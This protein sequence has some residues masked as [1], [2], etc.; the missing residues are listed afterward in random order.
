M[1][2]CRQFA[3]QNLLSG[4]S[5]KCNSLSST[6][7]TPSPP[8]PLHDDHLPTQ[9]AQLL[10]SSLPINDNLLQ[11]ANVVYQR[12][13][14]D[15]QQQLQPIPLKADRISITD[16]INHGLST[17]IFPPPPPPL[18][19]LN[20][21][22][23]PTLGINSPLGNSLMSLP[24][25]KQIE[26]QQL[27]MTISKLQQQLTAGLQSVGILNE[28][29]PNHPVSPWAKESNASWHGNDYGTLSSIKTNSSVPSKPRVTF[30]DQVESNLIESN[31]SSPTVD[32]DSNALFAPTKMSEDNLCD[33][34]EALLQE[35]KQSN[36]NETSN[37]QSDQEDNISIYDNVISS[38]ESHVKLLDSPSVVG[39]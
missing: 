33:L 38:N 24:E 7:P 10:D 12:L 6:D 13:L 28:T 17:T 4:Q 30:A 20:T 15:L 21:L 11:D 35:V 14:N 22:T 29:L 5:S 37:N 23:M 2:I 26:L 8:Q 16:S 18:T 19:C 27:S 25:N 9:D 3:R 1:P 39:A 34:E 31:P 32:T 36:T